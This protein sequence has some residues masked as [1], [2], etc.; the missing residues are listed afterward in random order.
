M[1]VHPIRRANQ[2][3]WCKCATVLI[4]HPGQSS[5]HL[6]FTQLPGI[7]IAEWPYPMQTITWPWHVVSGWCIVYTPWNGMTKIPVITVWSFNR[8]LLKKQLIGKSRVNGPSS[9]QSPFQEL[10]LEVNTI[11]KAHFSGLNFREYPYEIW[12][13]LWYSTNLPQ[14]KDPEIHQ[15]FLGKSTN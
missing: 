3:L 5:I 9:M 4:G 15:F 8:L 7:P 10:Q 1:N 13:K 14:F 2:R 11:Y 12:V 6:R